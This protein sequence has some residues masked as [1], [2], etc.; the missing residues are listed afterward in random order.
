MDDKQTEE[1]SD[2]K[3]G[4][5]LSGTLGFIGVLIVSSLVGRFL[6]LLGF[7]ALILGLFIYQGLLVRVSKLWA[8]IIAIVVTG[9]AYMVVA[10]AIFTTIN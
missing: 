2:K 4:G 5:A 9:V 1:V 6:G 8:F 3:Q 7:G 10:G